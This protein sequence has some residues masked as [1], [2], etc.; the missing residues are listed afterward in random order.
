MSEMRR[1]HVVTGSIGTSH[2]VNGLPCQDAWG[3]RELGELLI[4]AISDGA[5]SA[6]YAELG[7]RLAVDNALDYFASHFTAEP[8]LLTILGLLGDDTGER[9][10]TEIRRALVSEAQERDATVQDFACTLLIGIF[11]PF[12]SVFYQIG[13]GVW[14]VSANEIQGAATWPTQG[15][16]AGQ[17]EFITS[18]SAVEA[19][20][21]SAVDGQIDWAIGMTDGLER[22]AINF[23]NHTPHAGFIEPLVKALRTTEDMRLMEAS[24][25][26]FLDSSK[27]C[28]RTDDDKSLAVISYA[29][30][31]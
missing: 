28:E 3:C 17:T 2:K 18:L 27:I 26:R 20:Q 21:F 6:K 16:F 10:L 14:C 12:R 8:D 23:G 7:S 4:V 30:D 9:A 29:A 11:H 22:L 24:L 19:L 31:L 5:G 13:D 25:V 1:K 15:E